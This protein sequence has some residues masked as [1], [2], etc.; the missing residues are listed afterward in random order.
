ML[1]LGGATHRI[2][3][4]GDQHAVAGGLNGAAGDARRSSD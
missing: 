1:D 3:D 2:N 4:T